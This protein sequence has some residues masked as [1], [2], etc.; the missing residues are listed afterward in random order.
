MVTAGG[1]TYFSQFYEI[2]AFSRLRNYY[3]NEVA[4]VSAD[5][6]P[7]RRARVQS[8]IAPAVDSLF[9][10]AGGQTG[11]SSVSLERVAR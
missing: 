9:S 7:T 2:V 11:L 5:F 4:V 6:C 1:V 3:R 10:S 8:S